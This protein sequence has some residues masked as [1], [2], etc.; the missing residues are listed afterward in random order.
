MHV[1]SKPPALFFAM[2]SEPLFIVSAVGVGAKTPLSSGEV[3]RQCPE[4]ATRSAKSCCGAFHA[5]QTMTC[6]CFCLRSIQLGLHVHGEHDVQKGFS[7]V[8]EAFSDVQETVAK[9]QK[10]GSV[11]VRDGEVRK[12]VVCV[13]ISATLWIHERCG[14]PCLGRSASIAVMHV[15]VRGRGFLRRQVTSGSSQEPLGTR[16]VPKRFVGPCGTSRGLRVLR[17]R[18]HGLH[19]ADLSST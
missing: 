4:H 6:L 13:V 19:A 15:L 8:Q 12:V 14:C 17:S 10:A 18:L 7:S 1:I 16:T 11:R 9:V 3:A 5:T 2:Y